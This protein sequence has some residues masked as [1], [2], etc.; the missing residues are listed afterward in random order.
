MSQ[1]DQAGSSS[2]DE[3]AVRLAKLEARLDAR[4]RERAVAELEAATRSLPE[5]L[6]AFSDRGY[7]SAVEV[8]GRRII[9]R[10]RHVGQDLVGLD[11]VDSSGEVSRVVVAASAISVVRAVAARPDEIGPIGSGHP[12]TLVALLRQFVVDG[13]MVT[14]GQATGPPL[15]GWIEAVAE[16]HV[17]GRDDRGAPWLMRLSAVTWLEVLDR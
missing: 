13:A 1:R 9:G 16:A 6:A 14:L 2:E 5:A 8:P 17:E 15:R 10:V 3:R 4:E 7:L 11:V 12:V